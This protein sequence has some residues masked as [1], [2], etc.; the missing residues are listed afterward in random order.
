MEDPTQSQ[1]NAN[2]N[3]QTSENVK[4]DKFSKMMDDYKQFSS[5]HEDSF[6]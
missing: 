3:T 5:T 2:E 1:G 4:V 6:K